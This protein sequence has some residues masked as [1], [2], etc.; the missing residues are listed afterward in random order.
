[1]SC[2]RSSLWISRRLGAIVDLAQGDAVRAAPRLVVGTFMFVMSVGF[3]AG[4]VASAVLLVGGVAVASR[5]NGPVVGWRSPVPRF[6]PAL[7]LSS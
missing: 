4:A 5:A 6:R 2:A 1:M 3:S 7:S